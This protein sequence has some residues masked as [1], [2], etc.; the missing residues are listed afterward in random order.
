MFSRLSAPE[1]DRRG[2]RLNDG[3]VQRLDLLS[4]GH[5]LPVLTADSMAKLFPC[6]KQFHHVIDPLLYKIRRYRFPDHIHG[7]Q[8]IAF[9]YAFPR[10]FRCHDK[11]RNPCQITQLAHLFQELKTIH[12]RHDH[13]QQYGFDP[14]R[15][16]DDSFQGLLAVFRFQDPIFLPKDGA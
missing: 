15:F 11:N 3:T 14:V 8:F 9:P 6:M 5:Q 12:D 10:I 7:S 1:L 4:L 13:I 16:P 2:Q